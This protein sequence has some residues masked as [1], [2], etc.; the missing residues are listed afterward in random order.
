MWRIKTKQMETKEQTH[1]KLEAVTM[2]YTSG[3]V[4]EE[5]FTLTI[6][7][8]LPNYSWR[9]SHHTQRQFSTGFYHIV[10]FTDILLLLVEQTNLYYQKYLYK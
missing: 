6:M 2:G 5:I 10:L 1:Q 8:D 9:I 3:G 7:W 4:K